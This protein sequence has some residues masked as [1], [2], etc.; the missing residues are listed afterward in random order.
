MPRAWTSSPLLA[1]P[2]AG[3]TS[4]IGLGTIVFLSIPAMILFFFLLGRFGPGSGRELLDWD[5]TGHAADAMERDAEDTRQMLEL[6]N[7]QRR[8]AGQPE[9]TEADIEREI[10]R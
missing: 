1:T 6:K 7:R 5:P 2:L 8:A 10:D 4:D 3:I 9:L